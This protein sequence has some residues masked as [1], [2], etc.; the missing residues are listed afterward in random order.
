MPNVKG[1]SLEDDI[2]L[3][4]MYS[5]EVMI[6]LLA[7]EYSDEFKKGLVRNQYLLLSDSP[8]KSKQGFYRCGA[9]SLNGNS[10]EQLSITVSVLGPCIHQDRMMT[11]MTQEE[12]VMTI[13]RVCPDVYLPAIDSFQKLCTYMQQIAD[14]EGKIT[15]IICR[16]F[17]NLDEIVYEEL[18]P[19]FEEFINGFVL[20]RYDTADYISFC[21]KKNEYALNKQYIFYIKKQKLSQINKI[22]QEEENEDD[23][24]YY[25]CEK[26]RFVK[27][28][29]KTNSFYVLNEDFNWVLDSDFM[30]RYY[31]P[32]YDFDKIDRRTCERMISANGYMMNNNTP[33]NGYRM[34][35]SSS[36]ETNSKTTDVIKPQIKETESPIVIPKAIGEEAVEINKS[37][38]TDTFLESAIQSQKGSTTREGVQKKIQKTDEYVFMGDYKKIYS[39]K[40]VDIFDIWHAL[41][42]N[43][44]VVDYL[45]INEAVDYDMRTVGGDVYRNIEDL[46]NNYLRINSCGN[47]I[48][49]RIHCKLNDKALGVSVS[50]KAQ[51]AILDTSD[52]NLELE[53]LIC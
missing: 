4:H 51:T 49:Y 29:K 22:Q 3:I 28:N 34:G 36:P 45:V 30:R 17:L 44:I 26:R 18:W 39:Y 42:N 7:E 53:D 47:N 50:E 37:V 48:S 25:V 10:W 46:S 11:I 33:E 9:C 8:R 32:Q 6:D 21:V 2:A 24:E 1:L 20:A 14:R 12:N 16:E 41:E 23:F 35:T 40:G 27:R 19:T 13:T 15:D 43:G 38:D 31:D 5:A 52:K